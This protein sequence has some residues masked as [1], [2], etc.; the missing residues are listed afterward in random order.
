MTLPKYRLRLS[1]ELLRCQPSLFLEQAGE[2]LWVLEA[3]GVGYLTDTV[4]G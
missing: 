4:G 1:P 3:E 2:V